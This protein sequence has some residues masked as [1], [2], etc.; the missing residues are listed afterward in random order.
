VR[1][2]EK[3]TNF[4]NSLSQEYKTIRITIDSLLMEATLAGVRVPTHPRHEIEQASR[5]AR[6]CLLRGDRPLAERYISILR[7]GVEELRRQVYNASSVGRKNA[8]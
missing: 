8:S 5:D 7:K 4:L 6:I 2:V 3:G 1:R